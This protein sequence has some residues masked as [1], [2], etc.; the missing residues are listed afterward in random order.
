MQAR[1]DIGKSSIVDLSQ[2]QLNQTQ[3]EIAYSNVTYEYLIQR[4]LLDYKTGANAVAGNLLSSKEI[5]R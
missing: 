4:A 2:S 1:Y 5:H 3:A